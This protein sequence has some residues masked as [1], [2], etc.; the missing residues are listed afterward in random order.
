[1]NLKNRINKLEK[2]IKER[3]LEQDYEASN[4]DGFFTALDPDKDWETFFKANKGK[5][6][7]I[8]AIDEIIKET[9]DDYL[10]DDES[11]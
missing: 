4:A 1:M 3:M 10:A 9:W 8:L 11:Q 6:L 7:T 5:D 2:E